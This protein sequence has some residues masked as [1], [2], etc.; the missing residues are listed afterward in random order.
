VLR[1][2]FI[3]QI[4]TNATSLRILK[5]TVIISKNITS[6]SI[7]YQQFSLFIIKHSLIVSTCDSCELIMK[8]W[9]SNCNILQDAQLSQRDRAAGCSIVCAKSRRL[10]L[11]DNI[12]CTL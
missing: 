8:E 1:Q 12:L 4:S 3:L 5:T 2:K 6:F 9:W 11:G 10:E 7:N